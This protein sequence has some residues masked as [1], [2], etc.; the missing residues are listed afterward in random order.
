[1]GLTLFLAFKSIAGN[2]WFRN[3]AKT[4]RLF[5]EPPKIIPIVMDINI[6]NSLL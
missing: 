2:K 3:F 4:E 6:D 5:Y 1:M